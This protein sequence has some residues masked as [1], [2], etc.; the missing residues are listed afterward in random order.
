[1]DARLRH[2]ERAVATPDGAGVVVMNLDTSE[3]VVLEGVSAVLWDAL[4]QGATVDE[5]VAGVIGREPDGRGIPPERIRADVAAFTSH[6]SR[7][8]LLAETA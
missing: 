8:G 7:L 6:L 3:L 4:A 2:S 5:I 1:M